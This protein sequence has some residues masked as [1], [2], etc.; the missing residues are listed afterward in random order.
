[1]NVEL[2]NIGSG[3]IREVRVEGSL[4]LCW[5]CLWFGIP[6]FL[7]KL[8]K[9]G[10]IMV[11]LWVVIMGSLITLGDDNIIMI[12]CTFIYIGFGIYLGINSPKIAIKNYLQNGW[13]FNEP[14][15]D[16][17]KAVKLR[18]GI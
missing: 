13:E 8:H 11:A 4:F 16:V 5:A 7:Q 15:S 12:L 14:D 1:M 9:L 10:A 17:S 2:K 18:L 3:A 6:L